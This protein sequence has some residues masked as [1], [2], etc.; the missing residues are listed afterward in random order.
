MINFVIPRFIFS[1]VLK[2]K[3]KV[4]G[5]EQLTSTLNQTDLANHNVPI[6]DQLFLLHYDKRD[7]HHLC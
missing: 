3:S 2:D 6:N 1:D 5:F 7:K 4:Q